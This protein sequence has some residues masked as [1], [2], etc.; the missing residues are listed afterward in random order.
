MAFLFPSTKDFFGDFDEVGLAVAERLEV[1]MVA[2]FWLL[3]D[4]VELR[5][6]LVG[7]TFA[8]DYRVLF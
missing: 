8:S 2:V 3:L 1:A 6:A 4:G 7:V 5:L